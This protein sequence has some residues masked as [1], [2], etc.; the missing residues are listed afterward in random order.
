ME[1]KGDPTVQHQQHQHPGNGGG[2]RARGGAGVVGIVDQPCSQLGLFALL[3]QHAV[4]AHRHALAKHQQKPNQQ[5]G[6]QRGHQGIGDADGPFFGVGTLAGFVDSRLQPPSHVLRRGF[7][8]AGRPGAAQI[9]RQ[10]KKEGLPVKLYAN[11]VSQWH[12]IHDARPF[13]FHRCGHG[14]G[15]QCGAVGR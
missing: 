8:Q 1:H 12:P 3:V 4:H 7:Q 5:P 13:G 9:A 2:A 11:R 10:Q 15:G 6:N 14:K